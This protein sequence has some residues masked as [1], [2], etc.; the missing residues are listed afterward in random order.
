[1]KKLLSLKKKKKLNDSVVTL[2]TAGVLVVMAVIGFFLAMV[3]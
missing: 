3:G 2:L 1:M